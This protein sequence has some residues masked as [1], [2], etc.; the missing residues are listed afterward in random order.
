MD[1]IQ[2]MEDQKE[3]KLQAIVTRL[4]EDNMQALEEMVVLKMEQAI[5][6][7]DDSD[8]HDDLM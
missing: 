5:N 1:G 3:V 4:E 2:G 6:E 8:S 7:D